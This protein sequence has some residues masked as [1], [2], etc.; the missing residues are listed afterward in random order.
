[1]NNKLTLSL[2][3]EVIESA[4]RYA[5][6][7]KTSVSALVE[8][9]FIQLTSQKKKKYVADELAGILDEKKLRKLKDDRIN[10]WLNK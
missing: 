2:K 8:N 9:Y 7:R 3:A 4:K 5:S 10:H 1:M 6:K